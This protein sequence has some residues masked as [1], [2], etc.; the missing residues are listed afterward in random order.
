MLGVESLCAVAVAWL[1]R[2]ALRL[3]GNLGETLDAGLDSGLNKLDSLIEERL[4]G[5]SS[6]AQLRAEAETDE[7]RALTRNRVALALQAAVET[8]PELGTRLRELV[9]ELDST[10][11]TVPTVSAGRDYV[12]QTGDGSMF[13]NTG[14]GDQH[15]GVDGWR[16]GGVHE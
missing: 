6:L 12:Q 10:S 16:R 13:V 3:S 15:V 4:S 2:Y 1:W 8:D 11:T 5:D 7:D 14:T 9:A